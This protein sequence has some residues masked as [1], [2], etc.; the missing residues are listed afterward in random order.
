MKSVT[1][2]IKFYFILHMIRTVQSPE[3]GAFDMHTYH[4]CINNVFLY[5]KK[6]K[7]GKW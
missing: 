7:F 5:K 3:L 2:K 6:P 1:L 4:P